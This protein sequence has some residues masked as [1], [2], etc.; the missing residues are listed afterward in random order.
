VKYNLKNLSYFTLSYL[1]LPYLTLPY[2]TLFSCKPLQQKRLN[3]FACTMAWT[4]WFAVMKYFWGVALIENYI[5]G[6]KPPKNFKFWAGMPNFQTN[7]IHTNN[8]CTVRHRRTDSLHKIG[9]GDSNDDVIFALG[10]HLATKTTSGP[11]LPRWTSWIIC[12]RLEIDENVNVTP[13]SNR[14]LVTSDLLQS[15]PSGQ[16]YFWSNFG[17]VK[18][19]NNLNYVFMAKMIFTVYIILHMLISG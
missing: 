16:Y 12:E 1:T 11:I 14:W 8:F 9:V 13:M 10:R 2:L 17:T 3:R 15:F 4:M 7:K 19:A 6:S 5:S 18:I